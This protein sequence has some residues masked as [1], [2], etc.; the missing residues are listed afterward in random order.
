MYA[1]WNG[2]TD[3]ARWRILAGATPSA[4]KPIAEVTRT[5]FE[6]TATVFRSAGYVAVQAQD[7]T[8]H[9]L[10]MSATVKPGARSTCRGR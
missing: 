3:V 2:A 9:E 1:S 10:G 8:G 6:T 4:L 5:G 7:P